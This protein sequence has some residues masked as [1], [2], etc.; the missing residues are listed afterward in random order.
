MRIFQIL[1]TIIRG[2][3]IGNNV[4]LLD[5]AFHATGIDSRIYA[6][7]MGK[8]LSK[9]IYPYD[10]LPELHSDDIVI[11]HMCES[12]VIN[13]DIKKMKCKKI[14]IYHNTTPAYF[15]NFY[16]PTMCSKQLKSIMEIQGLKDVFDRCIADSEFNKSDLARMGYDANKVDVVPILLDFEDYTQP[17]DKKTI[18]RY[19]DGQT[20][21]L[22]VGRIVPNK[23]QEDIIRIFGWYRKNINPRSRLIIVG[24]PFGDT[25]I[26]SL[27][28]YV[29]VL[30]IPDVIFTG[31]IT[32]Q[33][34]LGFYQI[35]DMFLCMSEHEGFC[36]PLLEA[37]MF[38][39]PIVAYKSTAIPWTLGGAGVL[40]DEKD[41]V[42]VSKIIHRI[43]NDPEVKG[44]IL[45]GQRERLKYF[46]R[47]IVFKEILKVIEMVMEGGHR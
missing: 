29:R 33:E 21:I 47:N 5:D 3:A 27:K 12:S 13:S 45:K 31:H 24:S 10:C 19:G 14:A 7:N 32:F 38:D 4:L 8:G 18:K 44:D 35:A 16:E 42:L 23:K 17:P 34:I 46:D 9:K 43:I 30:N 15:F 1:V 6:I 11:Y 2:D 41:P 37:M 22:F 28:E 39:V 20:N 40:V 36:V 26:N 25:Y